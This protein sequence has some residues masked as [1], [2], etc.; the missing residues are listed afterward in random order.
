MIK[1]ISLSLITFISL[2]NVQPVIAHNLSD[3]YGE[4]RGECLDPNSMESFDA[5]LTITHSKT[6]THNKINLDNTKMN[7]FINNHDSTPGSNYTETVV[8]NNKDSVTVNSAAFWDEKK[9]RLNVQRD[10]TI[11]KHTENKTTHIIENALYWMS[12]DNSLH[13]Q[14]TRT[15]D[16]N[17]ALNCV[18]DKE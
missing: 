6:H 12:T 5:E 10:F 7:V 17:A 11:Y 8:L 18:F 16:E 13:S 2:S 4:W 15:G 9:F 1:R 3:F 14:N